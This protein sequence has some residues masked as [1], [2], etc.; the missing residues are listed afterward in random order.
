MRVQFLI[1]Y[2]FIKP[3]KVTNTILNCFIVYS[4]SINNSSRTLSNESDRQQNGRLTNLQS[5]RVGIHRKVK[6]G[7][8]VSS[9][10]IEFR[11][12]TRD[13]ILVQFVPGLTTTLSPAFSRRACLF[14]ATLVFVQTRVFNWDFVVVMV[15]LILLACIGN[16]SNCLPQYIS[17]INQITT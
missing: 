16:T 3:L 2:R 6:Y 11:L 17:R 9:D 5:T 10:K 15:I 14:T 4:Q 12:W 13:I 8:L 7:G 1:F